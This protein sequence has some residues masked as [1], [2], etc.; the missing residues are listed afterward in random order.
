VKLR[1]GREKAQE[2]QK[3]LRTVVPLFLPRKAGEWRDTRKQS[4]VNFVV[5]CKEDGTGN[6]RN[7]FFTEGN[8]ATKEW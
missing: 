1:V 8:E 5:F 3:K 6:R 4:F 7:R 2:A